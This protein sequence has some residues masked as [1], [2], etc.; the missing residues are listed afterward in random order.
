MEQSMKKTKW[1]VIALCMAL[2]F[3]GCTKKSEQEKHIFGATYMT[4]NNPYFD[5][6]NDEIAEGV[7][8][9]GDKLIVRDPLQDQE[10]QNQQI[11][12]MIDEGIE[13]LFLNPVDKVKVKPALQACKKAGVEIIN[14]DTQVD[15]SEY[16]LA[17]IETDNYQAGQECAR[18]MMKRVDSARII[19]LDNS[20]QD[21]IVQR[22][23]GFLDTI[24]RH[25]EY[26]VVKQIFSGG[27]IEI[28]AEVVSELLDEDFNVVFGGND[29]SAL[30]ALAALQKAGKEEG[31]LI[32]GIDGSPDFKAMLD[33]G[34]VT[35]T[36]SQSPET[37]GKMA[38][39]MAYRALRGEPV[40]KYVKLPSRLITRENLKNYDI[41]GW[42]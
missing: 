32:Y 13:I 30:G 15:D 9:N 10:K 38:T 4:R 33:L 37:I 26:Q 22:V 7:E 41:D 42:Q 16:V 40:E 27:E 28:S 5:V 17:T 19:I 6:L 3:S 11:L 12:D 25:P 31:I 18:D 36:S 34:Y 21:S 23:R 8:A 35:G 39:E 29:P 2:F 14:I 20:M 24:E 1:L